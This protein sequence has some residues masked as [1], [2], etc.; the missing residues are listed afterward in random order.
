MNG[1]RLAR[2]AAV[3]ASA[4][5]LTLGAP[6]AMVPLGAQASWT[7]QLRWDHDGEGVDYYQVC[8]SGQ[9][10]SLDAVRGEGPQ[11][12]APLPVLPKGEHRVVLKAC[13]NGAC[14]A[15][16][17]ELMVRVVSP[18]PRRLPIDVVPIPQSRT[19]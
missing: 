6:A 3:A 9:C 12:R 13:G 4:L 19:P 10:A 1:Q 15:G 14:T 7:F 8:V 16:A 2:R 18:S 17:P 11:W 5:A